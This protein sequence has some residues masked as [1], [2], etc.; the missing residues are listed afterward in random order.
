VSNLKIT[1]S[2][3]Q[4]ESA[5]FDSGDSQDKLFKEL[6]ESRPLRRGVRVWPT[7]FAQILNGYQ[8]FVMVSADKRL[9]RDSNIL[10]EEYTPDSGTTGRVAVFR[11]GTIARIKNHEG[12][13][14]FFG[15][16]SYI[17][18]II[19]IEFRIGDFLDTDE[20]L[21]KFDVE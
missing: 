8:T 20:A 12:A 19:P 16:H 6:E 11:V 5:C 15:E 13:I 3:A 7:E 17:V 21:G 18:S 14:E 4:R 2:T 10:I 9:D 1:M